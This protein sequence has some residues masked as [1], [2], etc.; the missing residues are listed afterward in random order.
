MWELVGLP[1]Q[2]STIGFKWVCKTM[3]RVDGSIAKDKKRSVAKVLHKNK[4][5]ILSKHEHNQTGVTHGRL[6]VVEH[7]LR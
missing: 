6:V 5:I 7:S 4:V 2:K 1:K 3:C